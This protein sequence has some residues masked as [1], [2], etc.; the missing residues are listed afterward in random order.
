[1]SNETAKDKDEKIERKRISRENLTLDTA[2]SRDA[3]FV[4]DEQDER[5]IQSIKNTGIMQSLLVRPVDVASYEPKSDSEYAI[6]AGSR[7][8]HAASEAG[9]RDLPCRIIHADD[10]T[11]TILSYKENEERKDLSRIER[12]ESLRMQF[13]ALAPDRPAKDEPWVCPDCGNEF[14]TSRGLHQH[15][16]RSDSHD[17]LTDPFEEG[18]VCPQCGDEFSGSKPLRDHVRDASDHDTDVL[19]GMRQKAKPKT[20]LDKFTETTTGENTD[21]SGMRQKAV[22]PQQAYKKLADEHFPEIYRT[23]DAVRKVKSFVAL[24]SLPTELRGLFIRPPERSGAQKQ[25]LSNFSISSDCQIALK[26]APTVREFHN[27]LHDI[28]LQGLAATDAVLRAVSKF[29]S[30]GANELGATIREFRESVTESD[31]PADDESSEA[32]ED[33]EQEREQDPDESSAEDATEDGG[34]DETETADDQL[35]A[36]SLDEALEEH[37][38]QLESNASGSDDKK[39]RSRMSATVRFSN[40][41]HRR[42]HQKAKQTLSTTSDTE[43]VRKAHQ[44]YLEQLAEKHEWDVADDSEDE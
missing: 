9:L 10:L 1:M 18:W 7:R 14:T 21:P 12:A 38:E 30:R 41:R 32:D 44:V 22:T 34:D 17:H 23:G 29:D 35:T 24:A 3:G 15:I 6:I 13:E 31:E 5:L 28:Q 43:V 27:D 8:Y 26:H 25:V 4:G 11:A 33:E 16:V 39:S 36:Q 20:T 42:L 37:Q 2:Q 40:D 19:V